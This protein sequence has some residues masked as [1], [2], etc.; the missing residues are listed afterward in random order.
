MFKTKENTSR[1]LVIE[2]S[3]LVSMAIGI[4]I[5]KNQVNLVFD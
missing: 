4:K 2:N 5:G 1:S 3:V